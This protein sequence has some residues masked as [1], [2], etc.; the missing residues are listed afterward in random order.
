LQLPLLLPPPPL[1]LLLTFLAV[2]C[3]LKMAGGKEDEKTRPKRCSRVQVL[4]S[5]GKLQVFNFVHTELHSS[6]VV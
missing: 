1:L 5:C 3:F 2:G 6:L 4:G